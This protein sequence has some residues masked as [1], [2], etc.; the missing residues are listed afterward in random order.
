[1]SR[2]TVDMLA[3]TA[4]TWERG[5]SLE[6]AEPRITALLIVG[7]REILELARYLKNADEEARC[8]ARLAELGGDA[9]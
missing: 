1:M 3:P 6:P 2:D 9:S 8:L 4:T 5:I 7:Y